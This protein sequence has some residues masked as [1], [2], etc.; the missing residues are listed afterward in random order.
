MAIGDGANDVNMITAAHVGIGIKGVEGQQAARASD[1][2]VGEFKILRRLTLFYG[3]E[4]Y[5]K[6]SL[7][8][9]YNFFKNMVLV[10]PQFW[11]GF[12]DGFSGQSTYNA[13]LFQLYNIV[14]ASLPIVIY[15][16]LD[17][18]EKGSFFLQNPHAY[19]Q[20]PQNKLFNVRIFWQWILFG[21]WQSGLILF[22]AFY[23][24]GSNFIDAD[25]GY[26]LNFWGAGMAVF[27][28]LI[29]VTNFKV[30]IM[31]SRHSFLSLLIIFGS[32]I[33]YVATYAASSALAPSFDDYG[34]FKRLF[35]SGNFYF[36]LILLVIMTTLFDLAFDRY[37]GNN[38]RRNDVLIIDRLPNSRRTHEIQE[39]A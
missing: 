32:I 8:I 30:L 2:S 28:F 19:F 6:N 22:F 38:I 21:V 37:Q 35:S 3:R 1:Y 14:Y 16:V 29:V 7:L 20:G 4:A 10:L 26:T 12:Y 9:C 5:R 11:F 36:V 27:G 23:S 39:N 18:E 24:V 31:S 15:A 13:F 17:K 34:T 25:S 33:L